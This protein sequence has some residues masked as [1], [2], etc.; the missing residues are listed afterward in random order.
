MPSYD[1]DMGFNVPKTEGEMPFPII[2]A[3]GLG[4]SALGGIFGSISKAKRERE[5][6]K[7]EQNRKPFQMSKETGNA[8]KYG[9]SPER[10]I[11]IYSLMRTMNPRSV[12]LLGSRFSEGVYNPD[13]FKQP[14]VQTRP[15]HNKTPIDNIYR[16]IAEERYRG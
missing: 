8:L 15:S 12:A 13:R 7:M 3:I 9:Y 14:P 16:G 6:L 11:N 2:E 5:A 4:V 1:S 10:G